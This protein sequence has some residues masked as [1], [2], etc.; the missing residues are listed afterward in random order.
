MLFAFGANLPGPE[1][2]APEETLRLSMAELEHAM[3]TPVRFSNLFT[4]PCFPPGAGPDYVNAAAAC[5]SSLPARHILDLLHEI[6][7]QFGRARAQRWGMRTLD[8]D[9]LAAGDEIHPDRE[10][11]DHWRNLP[12]KTQISTTPDE[13]V[14]PHPRLQDRG[15]VLVPLAEVAP[16]WR[17]PLLGMTVTQM[18]DA[19]PLDQLADIERWHPPE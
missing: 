15:F 12:L 18:R 17:H 5:R 7:R 13:L 3:D 11:Q 8:I 14:L 19:L 1:G 4:T 6:E 10:A 16:D 9:L 2:T